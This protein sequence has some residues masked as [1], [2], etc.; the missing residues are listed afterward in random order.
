[1]STRSLTQQCEHKCFLFRNL[2]LALITQ[3]TRVKARSIWE[4]SGSTATWNNFTVSHNR[5]WNGRRALHWHAQVLHLFVE[6]MSGFLQRLLGVPLDQNILIDLALLPGR[7]S[8]LFAECYGERR[9]DLLGNPPTAHTGSK[10]HL[11]LQSFDSP[12]WLD[13]MAGRLW[14]SV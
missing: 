7:C 5:D 3:A 10:L 4:L 9:R 8:T 13:R 6:N 14:V 2:T 11:Q 12:S 1:M